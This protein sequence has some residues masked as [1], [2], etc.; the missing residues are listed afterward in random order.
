MRIAHIS[1][2]YTSCRRIKSQGWHKL[3]VCV[4]LYVCICLFIRQPALG[5]SVEEDYSNDYSTF[6]RIFPWRHWQICQSWK[7]IPSIKMLKI[8][9]LGTIYTVLMSHAHT[10]CTQHFNIYRFLWLWSSLW[11]SPCIYMYILY[12][13]GTHSCTNA[14]SADI[15]TS[16]DDVKACFF[17]SPPTDPL[18]DHQTDFTTLSTFSHFNLPVLFQA[19]SWFI[20]T[21]PAA[22]ASAPPSPIL[23]SAKGKAVE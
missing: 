19:F 17:F 5:S 15:S 1:N 6:G 4:C 18:I 2:N 12:D 14:V 7:S 13:P 23:Q 21:A 8:R 20:P 3:G 11:C 9:P 10:H 22:W 16:Y